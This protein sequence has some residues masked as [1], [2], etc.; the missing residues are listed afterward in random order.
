MTAYSFERVSKNVYKIIA[1]GEST[2]IKLSTN[3]DG[4]ILLNKDMSN[5][6]IIFIPKLYQTPDDEPNAAIGEAYKYVKS[7][8]GVKAR[9]SNTG[10]VSAE[11]IESNTK[12]SKSFVESFFATL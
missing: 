9:C 12:N 3:F 1:F 8:T 5:D 11:I 2:T 4:E 10:I 7:S 6:G